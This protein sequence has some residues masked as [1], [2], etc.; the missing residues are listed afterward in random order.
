M[1]L[2]NAVLLETLRSGKKIAPLDHRPRLLHGL[3]GLLFGYEELEVIR[4][5]SD[6]CANPA[7]G[8]ITRAGRAVQPWTRRAQMELLAKRGNCDHLRPTLCL[9]SH[10]C[11][12]SPFPEHLAE[13][14]PEA[15]RR[16][17]AKSES[18]AHVEAK[19]AHHQEGRLISLG[20][21]SGRTAVDNY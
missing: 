8:K 4:N 1:R 7:R 18:K 16:K 6:Q 2:R 19:H 10:R 21:L 9:R 14:L 15:D 13:D 3:R 12:R 20:K 11:G 17:S 5:R